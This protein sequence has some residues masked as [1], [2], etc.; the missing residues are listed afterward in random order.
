VVERSEA[1]SHIDAT[2]SRVERRSHV[3]EIVFGTQDGLLTSLGLVSGVSGATTGRLS[4]LIAGFAGGVAGMLAMGA[5]AYIAAKS[6]RDVQQAELR[7]ES[8]EL[9]SHPQREMQELVELF[10]KDGLDKTDAQMVARVIS[11][12]P[13]A[14]LTAMAQKELGFAEAGGRPFLDGVVIAIA[15]LLGAAI[16][17]LPWFAAPVS[18]IMSI[19]P[20]A[21]SAALLMSVA[22]TAV[23]LFLIGLGKGR[24]AGGH[25]IRSGVEITAI[26]LGCALVAFLLGTVVP[27]AFGLHPLSTG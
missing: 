21:P 20:F 18:T 27:D 15:F 1:T 13:D 12:H 17:I 24:L 2:R 25:E 8:S 16:P 4:V 9:T 19:G 7:H 5:G 10:T 3:R 6:Q 22:A 14:M 23:A 11:K 26:G